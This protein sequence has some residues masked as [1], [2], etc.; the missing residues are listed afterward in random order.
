MLDPSLCACQNTRA[1]MMVRAAISIIVKLKF[2][3]NFAHFVEPNLLQIILDATVEYKKVATPS[4]VFRENKFFQFDLNI[5][6]MPGAR[7]VPIGDFKIGENKVPCNCS[8]IKV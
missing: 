4:L 3:I 6:H 5:L 2:K 1:M 7:N 8:L